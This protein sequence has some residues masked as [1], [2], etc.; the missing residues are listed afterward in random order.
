MSRRDCGGKIENKSPKNLENKEMYKKDISGMIFG[1][2]KVIKR[3]PTPE[4][5][6]GKIRASF[7]LCSCLFNNCGKEVILS[8]AWLA[9]GRVKTCGCG[10]YI[11]KSLVGERF[12]RLTVIQRVENY[13][14][15]SGKKTT[16][17]LCLCDCGNY[18]KR[19]T[20]VLKDKGLSS[21][22]C[23]NEERLRSG[24][25]ITPFYDL[26][27]RRFGRLLVIER[28]DQNNNGNIVLWNCQCDCGEITT[29]TGVSLKK[30]DTKSCGCLKGT[31]QSWVALEL[32]KYCIEKYSAIPEYNILI[33]P[34]TGHF[35]PYDIYLPNENIFVE[36]NGKQHYEPIKA[37][38]LTDDDFKYQ[39]KK[40]RI[41]KKF[42][43]NNGFYIEIDLRKIKTLEKAVL[44]L[45]K[46]ISL[47][48]F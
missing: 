33:N 14:F 45:E 11:R 28:H 26:S 25:G 43:K 6:V 15:P 12:G 18:V 16:Q 13:V 37:Y 29:C 48:D 23:Y 10:Q 8:R 38:F 20:K 27:G 7:W 24:I 9:T 1:N 30:G 41:K 4:K 19:R 17:W 40:D 39:K 42:A 36:V 32:K 35:L 22:G 46:Q 2:F 31:N 21:C 5:Y 34:E 47:L 3:V 44:F